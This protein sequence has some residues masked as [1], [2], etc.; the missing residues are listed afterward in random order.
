MN[1]KTQT[2]A[3]LESIFYQWESLLSGLTDDQLNAPQSPGE[4]SIKD[5]VGH[6]RA[7]QQLSIARLEAAAG[8]GEP[9]MPDWTAGLPPDEEEE[10]DAH[11][12]RIYALYHDQPWPDVH[13]AWRE[14]FRRFLELAGAIPEE[15][16]L[17]AGRYPWLEGYALI[18]VVEGSYEHHL[19][20]IEDLT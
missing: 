9:V 14:G 16:L 2:L 8:G 13:R 19:E 5:V 17:A 10:L 4:M 11:N 6:L 3:Q 20:Y 15:D 12:A 18:D 7:W 1:D